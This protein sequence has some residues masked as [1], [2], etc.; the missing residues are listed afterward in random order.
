MLFRGGAQD[1]EPLE[2]WG[3]IKGRFGQLYA[4]GAVFLL[5]VEHKRKWLSC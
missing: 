1:V 5:D 4:D 3:M 2:S